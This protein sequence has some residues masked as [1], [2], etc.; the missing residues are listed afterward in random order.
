MRLAKGAKSIVGQK[1]QSV[2]LIKGDPPSR[3]SAGSSVFNLLQLRF[4]AAAAKLRLSKDSREDDDDIAEAAS[5]LVTA[6][7]RGVRRHPLL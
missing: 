2:P 7:I 3:I 6:E 5:A 4:F 1:L